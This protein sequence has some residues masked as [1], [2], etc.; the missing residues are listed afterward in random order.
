MN[1]NKLAFFV[2]LVVFL[3]TCHEAYTDMVYHEKYLST[4]LDGLLF[5]VSFF[6]TIH[7]LFAWLGPE[8][9]DLNG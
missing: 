8:S 4:W 9:H 5:I 6:I 7:N 1:L 3:F 2:G